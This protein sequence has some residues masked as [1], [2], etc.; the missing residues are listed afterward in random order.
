MST[1]IQGMA[2]QT[3]KG[4]YRTQTASW[5][6]S[7]A[8]AMGDL[9]YKETSDHYDKS[10]SQFTWDTNLAQTQTDFKAVFRGV[11]NA[12]RTTLQTADGSDVLDGPILASGEFFFP[13]AALAAALYVANNQYVTIGQ[14]TGNT[15]N[16]A[17]VVPTT[18]VSLAIG[19]LTRDAVV[20]A[21]GLYFEIMPATFTGGPQT[22]S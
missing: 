22:I 13:C 14:G 4:P 11:S 19:K 10:A 12:R 21:T 15:L 1:P 9:V 7:L 2:R 20:G 6:A 16:P 18:N 5:K 8:V 3:G 17:L